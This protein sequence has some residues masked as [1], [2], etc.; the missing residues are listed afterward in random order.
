MNHRCAAHQLRR[1]LFIDK[2]L[3]PCMKKTEVTRVRRFRFWILCGG[4]KASRPA[5]QCESEP[6][7]KTG[8]KKFI[9]FLPD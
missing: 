2:A 8:R 7:F 6:Y 9:P 4:L 5:A 3:Q 1:I